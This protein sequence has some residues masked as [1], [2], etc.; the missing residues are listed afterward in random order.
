MI[1]KTNPAM[2]TNGT[3]KGTAACTLACASRFRPGL[4]SMGQL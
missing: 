3:T 4:V 2:I 1:P